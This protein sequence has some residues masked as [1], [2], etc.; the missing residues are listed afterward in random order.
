M[1]TEPKL[2][3]RLKRKLGP[4]NGVFSHAESKESLKFWMK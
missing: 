2:F 1:K 4:I 3:E